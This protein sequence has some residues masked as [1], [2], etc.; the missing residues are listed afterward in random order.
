MKPFILMV[1]I[2][3]LGW[4]GTVAAM[5][6][7]GAREIGLVNEPT[8]ENRSCAEEQASGL[9]VAREADQEQQ[10]KCK[11]PEERSCANKCDGEYG[12]LCPFSTVCDPIKHRCEKTQP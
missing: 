3:V 10:A 12:M 2:V 6:V 5:T 9:V 7:D 8:S 4:V 11:S 1:G